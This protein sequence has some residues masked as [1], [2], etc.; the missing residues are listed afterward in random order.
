MYEFEK[1]G[2]K[3][4]V[5]RTLAPAF[6]WSEKR[7]GNQRRSAALVQTQAR[8]PPFSFQEEQERCNVV[9]A[10]FVEKGNSRFVGVYAGEGV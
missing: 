10:R 6:A 2:V 3:V 1:I 9:A 4:A 5:F 7:D 8:L